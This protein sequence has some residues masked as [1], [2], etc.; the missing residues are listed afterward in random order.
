MNDFRDQI[1]PTV[2]VH[3][4]TR[5]MSI[6]LN[7]PRVLNSLDLEMIRFIDEA[8]DEVESD[9]RFQ[10]VLLYGAGDRGFCA[11]GDIKALAQAVQQNVSI[12]AD[13]ILGEEYD[14]CLRLHRFPKP[15]IALADGITMGAGLGLAAA[16]DILVATE[17]TRMAMPETRI[18]F[19]PDVGATG[20]MF[21]KCPR[22]YPEYLG[23][24]GYEMVGAEALR[25]GLA[26]HLLKSERMSELIA[27]LERHSASLS[28]SRAQAAEDLLT[29]I[30]HFFDKGTSAKPEMDEWVATYFSGKSS[31]VEIMESLRQCTIQINL[32]D[33]VFNRL[34]E[35]SPTAVVLTLQLL[36][37]N[38]GRPI[39]EVFQADLK[40]ATFIVAHPDYV[41]GVRARL[42]DKDDNPQWQPKTIEEVGTLDV[43]L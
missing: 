19:F 40:A 43:N 18:G 6:V 1:E 2:L 11:G 23:L 4:H 14:L 3:R 38:E 17:R 36:R 13:Q 30:D 31:M 24:T 12:P 9:E 28:G 8:L 15:V 10:F 22:G 27:A 33:G 42:V 25:L 16:G 21:S 32:C 35:R 7:R 39:E 37:H 29:E 34:A 26:T 20:W 41:E 5:M